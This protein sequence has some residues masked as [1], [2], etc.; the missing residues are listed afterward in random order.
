MIIGLLISLLSATYTIVSSTSVDVSGDV[1][2]RSEVVYSRTGTGQKDRIT[3]GNSCTLRLSGWDGCV[4]HSVILSMH[5]NTSQGAG[6]LQMRIGEDLVWDIGDTD[7]ANVAWNGSFSTAWVEI[8]CGLDN[9]SGIVG[10]GENIEIYIEASKN[11]LY[12][13]SYTIFYTLPKPVA[14]EVKFVSGMTENPDNLVEDSIGSGVVL[15]MGVDTVAWHFLGWSEKEV[16]NSNVCPPLLQAGERY[17]PKSDCTLWAV[18]SDSDRLIAKSDCQSG[19]Y[20]LVNHCAYWSVA[21]QGAVLDDYQISTTDVSVLLNDDGYYE[22]QTS[23]QDDM[24][25]YIEFLED[26]ML[27]I[28]HVGS[29]KSI[30]FNG[31]K[32]YN[33]DVPWHYR[34][35]GDGTL[36]IYYKDDNQHRILSCGYGVM[37]INTYI[38]AYALNVSLNLMKKNGMLLFPAIKAEYTSWP[39]GKYDAVEDVISSDFNGEESEYILYFGMYEL[40]IQNGLKRLVISR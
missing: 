15:P 7:F 33:R 9:S 3:A 5:S 8:G 37:E 21:L 35:L 4:I 26:S 11:S 36:C 22:L 14:H 38:M 28:E 19:N 17:F 39:F 34:V 27:T 20:I 13:D 18:Y 32:L 40:H 1:P 12:I 25:Y 2:E 31:T 6:S 24:V 23:V 29:Q 10:S 30:G 16:M